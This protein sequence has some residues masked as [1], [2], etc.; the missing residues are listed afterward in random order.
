MKFI[1]LAVISILPFSVLA[2]ENSGTKSVIEGRTEYFCQVFK[3][4]TDKDNLPEEKIIAAGGM[5]DRSKM[6]KNDILIF[7]PDGELWTD[8][9]RLQLLEKQGKL[10][11]FIVLIAYMDLQKKQLSISLNTYDQ[12]YPRFL[13]PPMAPGVTARGYDKG[14]VTLI[15]ERLGFRV[16]CSHRN[17]ILKK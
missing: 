14:L 9:S 12:R 15:D 17:L 16:E 2:F 3:S 5:I 4:Y 10:D 8:I 11:G 6:P 1:C 13:S 7:S